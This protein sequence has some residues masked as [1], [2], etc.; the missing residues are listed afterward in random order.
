MCAVPVLGTSVVHGGWVPGLGTR[1]GI[2]GWV[3]RVGIQGC[4]TQPLREGSRQRSGPRRLLQGAGVGGLEPGIPQYARTHPCGARSAL[5]ASLVLPGPVAAS[6]PIR[7]RFDLN[8]H[9]YCQNDEVSP[10]SVHKAYRSPYFQN[11]LQISPLDFLGFPYL[12]AF[13]PKE[14]MVPF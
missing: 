3:Y 5:W 10:K 14:L 8:S 9:V 6:W 11:G 13:S 12:L 4:T 1:V 7:A 2:P